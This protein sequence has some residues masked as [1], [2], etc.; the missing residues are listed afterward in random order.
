MKKRIYFNLDGTLADLYSVTN[1]LEC[2]ENQDV[3]PYEM[4]KPCFRLSP[5]ARLLNSRQSNG[6][7]ICIISWLSKTSSREYDEAVTKAK[8]IWLQTH[9]PSVLFD[10]VIILPYGTPKSFF[11]PA[12]SILFDDSAD[13]RNDWVLNG[14]IAYDETDIISVLKDLLEND[15]DDSVL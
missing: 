5:L 9:L 6:C 4:C 12:V 8:R 3:R 14:G 15:L 11:A 13:V 7:E 10:E 1:W 2:L